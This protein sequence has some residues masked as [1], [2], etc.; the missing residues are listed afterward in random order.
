MVLAMLNGGGGTQKAIG[1]FLH[2]FSHFEG[3]R[4]QIPLFKGGGA[5]SFTLF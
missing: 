1:Q 3:G 2:G 4:T 5:E